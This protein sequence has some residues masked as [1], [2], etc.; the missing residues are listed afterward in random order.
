MW[1]FLLAALTVSLHTHSESVTKDELLGKINP[2]SH[3]D[4]IKV[5]K[6][7]AAKDADMYLRKQVYEAFRT[8]AEAAKKEGVSL[9]ILSATR[10]FDYQKGIWER[11]WSREGY[12][13][14]SE[15]SI[16]RDIMRY[17]AMPGTSRHH[18]GTDVDFNSVD[19]S[20]FS[21]GTGR[22]VYEWLS[23]NASTFGFCQTYSNKSGGRTG[24]EEEKWHWTY[25]PLSSVYLQAYSA[26]IT[27]ADIKGFSGSKSAKELRVI[28]DYVLGIDAACR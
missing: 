15:A 4:F 9:K 19:P 24:Y 13:G 7:H 16:A 3:S 20:Y 14:Q 26:Q 10:T 25:V 2:A 18:W 8:M 28:E 12:K 27:Y 23:T 1:Y 5:D 6:V 21:T 17:S 22:K 11:K